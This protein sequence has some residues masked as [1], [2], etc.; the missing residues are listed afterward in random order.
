MG[1]DAMILQAVRRRDPEMSSH[2]VCKSF[3]VGTCPHDLFVGTKQDLGR[4]PLL[5]LEKHKIEYEYRTK[6]KGESFPEFEQAYLDH[7]QKYVDDMN[8]VIAVAQKRLERTPEEKEKIMVATRELDDLDTRMALMAQE[9]D[10]LAAAGQL[11][12]ALHQ[13]SK[14]NELSLGR[15]KLAEAVRTVAENVGQSSQQKLQVCEGCGAYLSRL[16]SDRRLADHF[17]GK[18]H[19]GFVLMRKAYNDLHTKHKRALQA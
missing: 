3:L 6:R 14:L 19:L 2:R 13:T 16:D 17:V 12:P 4:C 8:R 10:C 18:I 5:H 7:L 9:I 15:E 1:K 11:V